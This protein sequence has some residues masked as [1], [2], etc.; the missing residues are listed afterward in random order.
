MARLLCDTVEPQEAGC[1]S[2]NQW[3]WTDGRERA[4]GYIAELREAVRF[5]VW[6]TRGIMWA[7]HNRPL[8]PIWRSW[9][10]SATLMQRLIRVGS[11]ELV[12]KRAFRSLSVVNRGTPIYRQNEQRVYQ[13][14][15]G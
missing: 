10:K 3:R 11:P 14:I 9:S 1:V 8:M 12:G 5:F 6:G 13:R 15:F 4:R 7:S 2:R